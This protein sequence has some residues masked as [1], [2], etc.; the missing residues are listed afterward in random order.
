MSTAQA[1]SWFRGPPVWDVFPINR[2]FAVKFHEILH[3]SRLF[4]HFSSLSILEGTFSNYFFQ[5]SVIDD[6]RYRIVVSELPKLFLFNKSFYKTS[7]KYTAKL[8]R[9]LTFHKNR[10]TPG[11]SRNVAFSLVKN[12]GRY[13]CDVAQL[14]DR[15][16][17]FSSYYTSCNVQ[18][19]RVR[20]VVD[21]FY[22]V[23]T[24]STTRI[25]YR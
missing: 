16:S 19:P 14:V 12:V 3:C 7:N 8:R 23:T 1:I 9:N 22:D 2:Q 24:G 5:I 15:W 21:L 20:F 4:V 17:L 18:T 25:F 10:R 13:R 11:F 6:N